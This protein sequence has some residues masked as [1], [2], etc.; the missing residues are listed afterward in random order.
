[1]LYRQKELLLVIKPQFH[2]PTRRC[3][4]QDY[5]TL[6]VCGACGTP[7][8]WQLFEMECKWTLKTMDTN[9]I[10]NTFEVVTENQTGR[11]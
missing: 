5:T 8:N 10:F 7:K 9:F 4:A 6:G 3:Y 1:M 11:G 2:C